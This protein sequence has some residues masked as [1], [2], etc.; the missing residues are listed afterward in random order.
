MCWERHCLKKAILKL[1][2]GKQFTIDAP[3]NSDAAKYIQSAQLNGKS[4]D[5]NWIGHFEI[6][7]G[8]SFNMSMGVKPNQS[9]GIKD[10]SYPYSF[11]T[12]EDAAIL[13]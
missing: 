8:G 10:A 4:Y 5:Q 9:R 2:N 11:S 6:Q 7:K 13:K 1:E 12:S 3:D